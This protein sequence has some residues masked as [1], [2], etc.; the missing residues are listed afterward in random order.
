[1]ARKRNPKIGEKYTDAIGRKLI[2]LE[3]RS[4]DPLGREVIGRITG[5]RFIIDGIE[6]RSR[7][8]FP[9]STTLEMWQEIWRDKKS[10]PVREMKI[11]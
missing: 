4:S 11:G 7:K 9:Y 1:M 8:A 10:V 5:V 6:K 3:V 2:V